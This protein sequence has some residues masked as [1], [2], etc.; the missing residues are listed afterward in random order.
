MY[1]SFFQKITINL[2][3]EWME[4]ICSV[5]FLHR[6]VS[7][8]IF[9]NILSSNFFCW[10]NVFAD[11]LM[12]LKHI[13]FIKLPQFLLLMLFSGKIW[14]E[15]KDKVTKE[16]QLWKCII[17]N[18]TVEKKKWI[19]SLDLMAFYRLPFLDSYAFLQA[20]N[21]FEINVI[22]EIHYVFLQVNGDT[23]RMCNPL[24]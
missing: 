2:N 10:I 23:I 14:T 7:K 15:K 12:E 19:C 1:M 24:I 20:K 4:K 9:N 21:V 8:F 3:H 5:Y 13:K 22:S 17:I 16:K 18:C 6:K 11:T